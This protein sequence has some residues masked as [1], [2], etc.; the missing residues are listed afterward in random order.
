MN[1][2]VLLDFGFGPGCFAFFG[3]YTVGYL[4]CRYFWVPEPTEMYS[5]ASS[6]WFQPEPKQTIVFNPAHKSPNQLVPPPEI[7]FYPEKTENQESDEE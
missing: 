7:D 5:N 4:V 1:L 6:V 2:F 3:C